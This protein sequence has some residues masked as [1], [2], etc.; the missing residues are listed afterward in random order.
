[1]G[2]C[3]SRDRSNKGCM[4]YTADQVGVRGTNV[5]EDERHCPCDRDS[6]MSHQS[7]SVI[8]QNMA[9]TAKLALTSTVTL[10][11][12]YRMPLLGFGVFQ[13][14]D[15]KALRV[16]GIQSGLSVSA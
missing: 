11:T 14:Y 3:L 10:S 9:S 2:T 4:A 6:V 15:T 13:N 12:G 5:I 7:Q 8:S 16:G 1:M